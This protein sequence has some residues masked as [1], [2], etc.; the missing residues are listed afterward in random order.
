MSSMW[1][2]VLLLST[3]G[4]LGVNARYWLAVWIDRRADPQFPWATFTINVSGSFAIGVATALL[5]RWVPHPHARLFVVV[6]FLGG[7]TTFSSFSLEALALV[8]RGALGRSL[9]YIVGSVVSG[10]IAVA[11]GVALGHALAPAAVEGIS[12]R[13]RNEQEHEERDQEEHP[14]RALV[15]HDPAV[16]NRV[17]GLGRKA[18]PSAGPMQEPA[19]EEENHPP[20]E[21]EHVVDKP[22]PEEHG[23]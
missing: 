5:A 18:H 11:L 4:A 7:Y 22:A 10:F 15:Q 17:D 12:S 16:L 13:S 19:S 9:A 23:S 2:R 6:G 20:Q 8:E 21:E 1:M 3:G 14:D